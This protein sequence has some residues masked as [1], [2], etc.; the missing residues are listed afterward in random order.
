MGDNIIILAPLLQIQEQSPTT[1]TWDV[2]YASLTN[3][4]TTETMR[5]IV[6]I[7]TTSYNTNY[8]GQTTSGVTG[9][10]S[11]YV[12][13]KT[14][15]G[16]YCITNNHVAVKNKQYSKVKHT[17]TDYLGNEHQAV[18]CDASPNYD[19]A[20]IYFSKDNIELNDIHTYRTKDLETNE[21]IVSL[22]QPKG[23]T[24]SI[25]FGKVTAYIDAP[26]ISNAEAY[27]S[28]VTFKVMRHDAKIAPGS[29]GG[30]VLDS[31]LQIAGVNYAG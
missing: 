3:T 20:I 14:T 6:T 7:E 10:G 28:N 19:L 4:I 30:P 15:K 11:G 9:S 13:Q 23:Q 17:V 18:L 12:C 8:W 29:S 1:K 22:G 25:T 21:P 24:N 16:Y 5:A 31:K 27:E 2:D 26:K